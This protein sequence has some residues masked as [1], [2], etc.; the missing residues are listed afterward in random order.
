MLRRHDPGRLGA[1]FLKDP[2]CNLAI[3]EKLNNVITPFGGTEFGLQGPPLRTPKGVLT[4]LQSLEPSEPKDQEPGTG[5]EVLTRQWPK[6]WRIDSLL[7][8]CKECYVR[9]AKTLVFVV[10]NMVALIDN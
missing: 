5:A 9:F 2:P 3:F 6:A 1:S 4:G 7:L 8:V 10:I